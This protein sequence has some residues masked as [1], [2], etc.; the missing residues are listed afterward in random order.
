MSFRKCIRTASLL[1][2]CGT[3]KKEGGQVTETSR[4]REEA[5]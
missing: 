2:Q 3:K 5:Y 1:G 4:S